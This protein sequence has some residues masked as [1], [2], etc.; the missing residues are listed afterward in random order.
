MKLFDR[1]K[2][3]AIDLCSQGLKIILLISASIKKTFK[4]FRKSRADSHRAE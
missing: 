2:G 1:F 4:K 3:G